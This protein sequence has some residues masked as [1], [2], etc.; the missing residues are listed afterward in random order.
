MGILEI[1]LGNIYLEELNCKELVK[2]SERKE[3]G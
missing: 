1:L 2:I 3:D